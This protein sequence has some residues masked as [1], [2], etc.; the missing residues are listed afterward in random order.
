MPYNVLLLYWPLM[1]YKN[2]FEL[3]AYPKMS[4]LKWDM[5]KPPKMFIA[6]ESMYKS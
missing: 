5:S 6:R 4:V 3:K 2:R 1:F